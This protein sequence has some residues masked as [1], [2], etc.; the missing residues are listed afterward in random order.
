MF[1]DFDLIAEWLINRLEYIAWPVRHLVINFWAY[2]LITYLLVLILQLSRRSMTSQGYSFLWRTL[3]F[4]G[5]LWGG[6]SLSRYLPNFHRWY[7]EYFFLP[8]VILALVLAK[9]VPILSSK[10]YILLVGTL[11][12]AVV[13]AFIVMSPHYADF[14]SN[15]AHKNSRWKIDGMFE[16]HKWFIGMETTDR[17]QSGGN[18]GGGLLGVLGSSGFTPWFWWIT[19]APGIILLLGT[20]CVWPQKN[21]AEPHS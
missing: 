8:T 21:S 20:C 19:D 17:M 3:L 13:F 5:V 6:Y 2:G 10:K 14:N 9:L 16:I 15:H 18:G 1:E 4:V 7:K 11:F 12:C